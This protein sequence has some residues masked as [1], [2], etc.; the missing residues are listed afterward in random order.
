MTQLKSL[1][2]LLSSI[3]YLDYGQEG[4]RGEV[5]KEE[6]VRILE[7]VG[8]SVILSCPLQNPVIWSK[9]GT[10]PASASQVH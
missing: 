2:C 7:N 6:S 5:Q 1:S 3:S 4:S 8:A 10:L 9:D